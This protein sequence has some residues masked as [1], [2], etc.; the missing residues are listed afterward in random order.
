MKVVRVCGSRRGGRLGFTLVELMTVVVIIAVLSAV[1]LT[2]LKYVNLRANVS[3]AQAMVAKLEVAIE[4]F[5]IDNGYYPTT[6]IYRVSQLKDWERTNSWMLL[7]QL[8]GG[9]K[10]Y[11]TFARNELDFSGG[12]TNIVDP[13]SNPYVYYRPISNVSYSVWGTNGNPSL[14]AVGGQVNT[15]TFD[16]FS[17]G[18]DGR[19]YV[20][21]AT[22]TA[23]QAWNAGWVA[24]QSA[25]DD[26]G[27]GRR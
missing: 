5:K 10:K 22:N 12:V 18:P 21:G 1:T 14:C 3:R 15:A 24:P 26:I 13:W 7:T 6:T 17:Y 4:D 23:P 11:L 25:I 2:A 19:T 9:S 16:L 8:T 27:N 20:P